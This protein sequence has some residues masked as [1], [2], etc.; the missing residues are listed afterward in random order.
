MKKYKKLGSQCKSLFSG[1][2]YCGKLFKSSVIGCSFGAFFVLLP[3][4]AGTT[5]AVSFSQSQDVNKVAT[6][7]N[8]LASEIHKKLSSGADNV[9][10]SPISISTALGMLFYGARGKTADEMRHALGYKVLGLTDS[11]VHSAFQV[12]ME[13]NNED[14][15]AKKYT[16]SIANAVL[17]QQRFPILAEYKNGL[18][19]IYKATVKDVD[20]QNNGQKAVQ[21]INNWVKLKTNGQIKKLLDSIDESTAISLLNAV[22]FKG[23][24]KTQFDPRN[25][26][27]NVFFNNGLESERVMVP[28]MYLSEVLPL[29]RLRSSRALELPYKSEDISMVIILPDDM[30]G[31]ARLEEELT[32]NMIADIRKQ[33]D[34]TKVQVTLPKFKVEYGK[35]L[36]TVLQELG[37]RNAFE[38]SANLSGISKFG[39]LAVS[40]VLFKAVI[41]VDEQGSEASSVTGVFVHTRT[42]DSRK[43]QFVVNHPFLFV[44]VDRK[45]GLVLFQGRVNRL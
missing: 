3:L 18:Q 26:R 20:F 21:E 10:F 35:T 19:E 27:L 24:W 2:M 16:L 41:E 29:A 30:N 40:Q 14:S 43:E 33:T 17:I 32:P 4:F 39:P 36:N 23:V 13:K 44:I 1:T 7:S 31:L 45:S 6:L 34:K 28:M 37:I 38:D 22:Y 15:A 25:T 42:S 5:T 12:L 11:G 8:H 9:I